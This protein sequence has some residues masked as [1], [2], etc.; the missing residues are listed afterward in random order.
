MARKIDR[1]MGRN[2]RWHESTLER[3]KE[4]NMVI[5][6]YGKQERT[7]ERKQYTEQQE[8]ATARRRKRKRDRKK[9]NG[10]YFKSLTFTVY[11]SYKYI[12]RGMT[13]IMGQPGV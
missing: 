9:S 13:C 12:R 5:T 10:Y 3:W 1:E 6:K 8:R 7:M 4:R 2:K 11:E